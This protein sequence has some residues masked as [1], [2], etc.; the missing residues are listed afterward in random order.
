M[1]ENEKGEIFN[2]FGERIWP[3]CKDKE[4]REFVLQHRNEGEPSELCINGGLK[5]RMLQTV[6]YF[7][8]GTR[9]SYNERICYDCGK[10]ASI[11]IKH[12][13]IESQQE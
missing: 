6:N 4:M 1:K 3:S 12:K 10:K 7:D 8:I 9:E 11:G 5:H 2:D 13:R